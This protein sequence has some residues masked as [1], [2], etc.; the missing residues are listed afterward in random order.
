[1]FYLFNNLLGNGSS[2]VSHKVVS[3]YT[4]GITK[5]SKLHINDFL[6]VWTFE[7][8][9]WLHNIQHRSDFAV[10]PLPWSHIGWMILCYEATDGVSTYKKDVHFIGVPFLLLQY[11]NE[12]F[13]WLYEGS[14]DMVPNEYYCKFR[15]LLFMKISFIIPMCSFTYS[16][17]EGFPRG[18]R[19]DIQ[20]RPMLL[21]FTQIIPLPIP[22][23]LIATGSFP[24]GASKYV[25]RYKCISKWSFMQNNLY[26]F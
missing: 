15:I 6:V 13:C 10:L 25:C 20:W 22:L 7:M 24:S 9:C 3:T 19:K 14:W 26:F 5:A 23:I 2:A 18:D 8:S 16:D 4:V 12:I 21:P 17:W 1:M 11:N